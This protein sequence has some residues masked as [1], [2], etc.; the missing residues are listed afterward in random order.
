M[1]LLFSAIALADDNIFIIDEADAFHY[2]DILENLSQFGQDNQHLNL[3][4]D[5]AFG[6]QLPI[7]EFYLQYQMFPIKVTTLLGLINPVR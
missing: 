4:V 3:L 6:N 2:N 5:D 7:E 1:I